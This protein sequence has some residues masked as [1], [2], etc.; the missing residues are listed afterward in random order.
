MNKTGCTPQWEQEL[1]L[2]LDGELN[3]DDA[4]RIETHLVECPACEEFYHGLTREE[5]LLAGHLR[6]EIEAN[7]PDSAFTHSVMERLPEHTPSVVA[8]L[9]HALTR[10]VPRLRWGTVAVAA[11]LLVCCVAIVA[12]LNTGTPLEE[13]LIRVV[14]NGIVEAKPLYSLYYVDND[15]GEFFELPDGSTLYATRGT[16][17]S[18]DSFPKDDPGSTIVQNDRMIS[19]KVG[20]VFAQVNRAKEAFSIVTANSQTRVFGT[21]FYVGADGTRETTVAVRKGRVYVDKI[22]RGQI[23]AVELVGGIEINGRVVGAKMTT[24]QTRDDRQVI[25]DSPSDIS[26]ELLDRLA[27]F[28]QAVQNRSLRPDVPPLLTTTAI[29][30]L[31][32][33]SPS[34][35]PPEN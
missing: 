24:V 15:N 33:K 13:Q 28:F 14:R 25:L 21:H 7:R 9:R 3:R 8:V 5:R 35:V 27:V 30:R 19:L 20:E 22:A 26:G 17:F 2:Y 11:T 32:D 31:L 18:I 1:M 4:L 12:T 10:R 6:H 23:G 34:S 29:T 16:W